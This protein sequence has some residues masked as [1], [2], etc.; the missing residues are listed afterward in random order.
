[1]KT[2]SP[3]MIFHLVLMI[4]MALGTVGGAVNFIVGSVNSESSKELFS[5]LTNVLL[6]VC[7]LAMLL[8]GA[9]YLLK[10]YEKKAA[11]FYKAFLLIHVAV[12]ALT[13]FIDAFFYTFNTLMLII[14]ILNGVKILMLLTLAF[15][16]DLKR[17]RTWFLFYVI[18]V[19]DVVALLLAIVNMTQVG[20]D[21]SFTG[22]VTALIADGTIGLSISG[23]FNDKVT[24]GREV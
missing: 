5:N 19:L 11:V 4:L 24:R 22:Y 1:M 10:N 12:C 2:K 16:K 20:F 3:V 14:C 9:L 18:L 15:A 7:I 6:M 21:F 8:M 13:I 17:E 23:K